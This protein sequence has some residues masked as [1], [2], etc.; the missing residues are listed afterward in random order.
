VKRFLPTAVLCLA[1]AL[2][3]SG[4]SGREVRGSITVL[5]PDLPV[6]TTLHLVLEPVPLQFRPYKQAV[7]DEA[8]TAR[9]TDVAPGLYRLVV[10]GSNGAPEQFSF[11][12]PVAPGENV[13][14]YKRQ[15]L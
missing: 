4:C 14:T 8:H 15:V 9:F 12:L 10:Y 3:L 11:V 6:E 13:V 2:L 1:A 7:V 5:A